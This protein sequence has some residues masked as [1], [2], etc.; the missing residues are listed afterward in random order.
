MQVHGHG[1]QE[2]RGWETLTSSSVESTV[3]GA[4]NLE[5]QCVELLADGTDH[6]TTWHSFEQ[7]AADDSWGDQSN[8]KT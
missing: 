7:G 6:E 2:S 5:G 1:P 3:A 4:N 8:S